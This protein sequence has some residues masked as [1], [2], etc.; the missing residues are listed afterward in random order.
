MSWNILELVKTAEESSARAVNIPTVTWCYRKTMNSMG[1]GDSFMD[2]KL[3]LP[4]AV[5]PLQ[6]FA[7]IIIFFSLLICNCAKNTKRF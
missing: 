6:L 3:F 1:V 7:G 4:A 5:I 2:T